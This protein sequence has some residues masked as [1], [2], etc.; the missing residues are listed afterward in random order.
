METTSKN[1]QVWSHGKN[2]NG[3]FVPSKCRVNTQT[4]MDLNSGA[5]TDQLYNFE[6]V[7][8]LFE[9]HYEY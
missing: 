9:G 2:R 8:Y 7:I 4:G 3:A 1:T 6:R 5:I